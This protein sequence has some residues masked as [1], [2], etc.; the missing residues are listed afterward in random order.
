M[1]DR[2][3]LTSFGISL[4]VHLLFL[5]AQFCSLEWLVGPTTRAPIQVIYQQE[6]LR[7]PELRD[8]QRE[9][10]RAK[11]QAA[12]SS[13]SSSIA[14]RQVDIRIPD[15]PLL[16]GL[17]GEKD[18]SALMPPRPSVVDL[19]NLLDAAQGDPVLLS[20]FSAIR[21]RI[22]ETANLHGW[23]AGQTREGLVYV[24][25]VLASSGIVENAHVAADRSA[26][27]PELQDVALRILEASGPFPPFPPS[28]AEERKTIVV[29]L[30]F[31]LGPS[32]PPSLHD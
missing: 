17:S 16:S 9:I 21:E 32:T 25:F 19:T 3:L 8:L 27:F 14:G 22:Q 18:L 26:P 31:L 23:L 7:R 15:R 2:A 4:S 1:I 20:Y 30:E 6:A 12:A 13:P 11:R 29:P 10:A 5:I 24:S 28:F